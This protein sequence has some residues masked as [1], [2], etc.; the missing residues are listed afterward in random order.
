MVILYNIGLLTVTIIYTWKK[1]MEHLLCYACKL[2]TKNF[3]RS[4]NVLT[5]LFRKP[6]VS[7]VT[8]T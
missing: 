7:K 5:K 8:S 6:V 1:A 3:L 2:W 4:D